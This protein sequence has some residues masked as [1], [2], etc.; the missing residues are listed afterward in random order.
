[1]VPQRRSSCSKAALTLSDESQ[2]IFQIHRPRTIVLIIFNLKTYVELPFTRLL[3]R[4]YRAFRFQDHILSGGAEKEFSHL[5]SAF[6]PDDNFIDSVFP[7]KI[8]DVFPRG[9]SANQEMYLRNNSLIIQVFFS[10]NL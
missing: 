10:I 8:Y 3:N 6:H 9:V 2:A 1:M 5:G 4:C 7:G